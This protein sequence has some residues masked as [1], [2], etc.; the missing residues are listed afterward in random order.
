MKIKNKI[1]EVG[2]LLTINDEVNPRELI[3]NA[4]QRK[5]LMTF[6]YYLVNGTL[7]VAENPLTGV[8]LIYKREV[9]K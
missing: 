9:T 2:I 4:E 3:L 1:N 6:I 8:E 5:D 7:E